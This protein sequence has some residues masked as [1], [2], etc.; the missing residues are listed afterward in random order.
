MDQIE[1]TTAEREALHYWRFHHPHPRVQ[2]TMEA[3][4][5]KSQGLSLQ[6]VC[7]LCAISKTTFYRY[8][9]EY[10]EGGIAKLTE[11]PFHRRHSQLADYRAIIEADF[12]QRPPASVAEAAQRIAQLTG[13]KRG[14]TQVRQFLKSLGM[15]P[16]KVGHIPAKADVAAQ[17]TFKTEELEPR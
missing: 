16:R 1:C 10:R 17:E 8:L 4:Y 12:R 3:L 9:D 5:L 11:V 7:R 15:K 2:C 6:D 13:L 14:L